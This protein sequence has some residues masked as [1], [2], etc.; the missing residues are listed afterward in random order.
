MKIEARI[1]QHGAQGPDPWDDDRGICLPLD[2]VICRDVD[3]TPHTVGEF[4]WPW[5]AYTA[6]RQKFYLHFF[7][8]KQTKAERSRAHW[9]FRP[10][11]KPAFAS[12]SS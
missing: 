5:T 2:H 8:W 1:E 9:W 11:A 6:H 4:V 7:Y 3:G 12:C 10:S